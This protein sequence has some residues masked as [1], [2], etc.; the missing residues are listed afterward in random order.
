MVQITRGP[1]KGIF[2]QVMDIRPNGDYSLWNMKN[3]KSLAIPEIIPENLNDP[4]GTRI[5]VYKY[6][7]VYQTDFDI[8]DQLCEGD[9]VESVDKQNL[10]S[11][12]VILV[13]D[14]AVTIEQGYHVDRTKVSTGLML[15]RIG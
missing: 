11:G 6:L 9:C 15:L 7:N 8:V 12:I 1:H 10:I 3:G 14:G 13:K 2:A 5:S 4:K